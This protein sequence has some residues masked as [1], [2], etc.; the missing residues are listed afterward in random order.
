MIINVRSLSTMRELIL[1]VF[2]KI[3][4]IHLIYT[5]VISCKDDSNIKQC[6]VMMTFEKREESKGGVIYGWAKTI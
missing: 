3:N 1:T 2:L 4:K 5:K 6:K